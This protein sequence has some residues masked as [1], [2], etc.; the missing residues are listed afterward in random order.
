MCS[1]EFHG[2]FSQNAK[3]LLARPAEVIPLDSYPDEAQ[4]CEIF[5]E[6]LKVF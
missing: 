6:V 5:Y 1:S 3:G 2:I 4:L